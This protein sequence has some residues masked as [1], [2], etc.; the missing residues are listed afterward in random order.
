MNDQMG[1]KLTKE[2]EQL[3]FQKVKEQSHFDDFNSIFYWDSTCNGNPSLEAA[4]AFF[5][6]A[7]PSRFARLPFEIL[8]KIFTMKQDAE[9]TH[10]LKKINNN[11]IGRIGRL[12][13]GWCGRWRFRLTRQSSHP[14]ERT[15]ESNDA[16]GLK[17]LLFEFR[18]LSHLF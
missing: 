2:I 8:W 5:A 13:K 10:F 9:M 16:R 18:D 7:E 3:K 4:I 6:E 1:Q 14:R 17:K 11:K 12:E 15:L